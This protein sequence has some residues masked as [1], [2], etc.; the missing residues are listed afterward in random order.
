[1]KQRWPE[2]QISRKQTKLNFEKYKKKTKNNLPFTLYHS[3]A[4]KIIIKP[5]WKTINN[6]PEY[7]RIL[8]PKNIRAA[9]ERARA[10]AG[11]KTRKTKYKP[12]KKSHEKIGR[13]TNVYLNQK[14][15]GAA[16]EGAR[17]PAGL[18]KNPKK[19]SCFLVLL[20]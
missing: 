14:N 3:P 12:E 16:A 19:R 20:L 17:A 6:R 8:K 15:N 7:K 11:Q 13:N 18:I 5:G 2:K 1:M 4:G 10:P 9:A